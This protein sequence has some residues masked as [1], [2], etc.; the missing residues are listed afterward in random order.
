MWETGVMNGDGNIV[1]DKKGGKEYTI[2]GKFKMG[3]LNGPGR[4]VY[5]S[6]KTLTGVWE[7]GDL[8]SGKMVN[9][10]GTTY[11]G[12]WVGG[13]PHGNGVK[14]ISGGK[15][16]EGQFSVGRPWGKGCKVSGSKREEGYWDKAKF[17]KGETPPEKETQFIE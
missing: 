15:R 8:V 9:V 4:R 5:S 12:D 7:D 10:D 1:I 17:I 13:R 2:E 16:Y 11:E 14:T 3:M 6:G